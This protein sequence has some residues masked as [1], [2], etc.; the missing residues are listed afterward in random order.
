[1]VTVDPRTSDASNSKG[2]C[3]LG[4]QKSAE[5]NGIPYLERKKKV[6]LMDHQHLEA[7]DLTQGAL[8][9]IA[10]PDSCDMLI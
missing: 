4:S 2:N 9:S 5:R 3:Q 10:S 8:H 1:M 6:I 7:N